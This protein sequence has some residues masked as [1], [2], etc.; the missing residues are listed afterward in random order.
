MRYIFIL[1]L[2]HLL[3]ASPSYLIA[4]EYYYDEDSSNDLTCIELLKNEK[5]NSD[6]AFLVAVA[7]DQGEMLKK[8]DVKALK[9]YE[10]SASLGDKDALVIS[11]WRYYK[12][13]GCDTNIQQAKSYFIKAAKHGDKEAKDLLDIIENKNIF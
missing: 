8:N 6:A 2:S 5:N 7:Y 3:L 13:I 11:G 1:V 4:L 12:G 9:Y 10:L